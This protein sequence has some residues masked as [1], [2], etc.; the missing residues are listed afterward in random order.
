MT[1]E[2]SQ[3]KEAK[4]VRYLKIIGDKDHLG[5]SLPSITIG[6]EHDSKCNLS[7]YLFRAFCHSKK[8]NRSITERFLRLNYETSF[9]SGSSTTPIEAMLNVETLEI[10]LGDTAHSIT[11]YINENFPTDFVVRCNHGFYPTK[12]Y[13]FG[14]GDKV[15]SVGNIVDYIL[16]RSKSIPEMK[17]APQDFI[18]ITREAVKFSLFELKSA[19]VVACDKYNRISYRREDQLGQ[20]PLSLSDAK[21]IIAHQENILN[22]DSSFLFYLLS[23]SYR[24][25]ERKEGGILISN[26]F[27]CNN[28][29]ATI[30]ESKLESELFNTYVQKAERKER[31]S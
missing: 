10:I 1:Q 26:M 21:F 23:Q 9:I 31:K 8:N 29:L 2:K 27:K 12:K 24:I 5:S 6:F 28:A 16:E 11:D 25:S 19:A 18:N 17:Y 30:F 3:I 4:D 14:H 15:F 20:F 13:N 7:T 22:S